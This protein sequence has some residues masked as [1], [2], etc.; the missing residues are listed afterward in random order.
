MQF[1]NFS[2]TNLQFGFLWFSEKIKADKWQLTKDFQ[3]KVYL[4]AVLVLFIV[5]NDL[6]QQP[7]VFSV[8][9]ELINVN[10]FSFFATL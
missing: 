4:V 6:P 10:T 3:H 7:G 9:M 2:A 1:A 5:L 8:I